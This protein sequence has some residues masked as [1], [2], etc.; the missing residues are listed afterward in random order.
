M[1]TKIVTIDLDARSYDIYIGNSLLF[2][3]PDF[4]PQDVAGKSI[5]I[6]TDTNV[7]SYA[8]RI[9]TLLT[10]NNARICAVHTLPAGEGTKSFQRVEEVCGWMLENGLSRDSIVMAVGG[11][12][13]GDLTG[14]CASVVMRGVPY[15]QVPTTLL[16]Q[17]DRSVGGKTGINSKQ[18]KNLRSEERRVGKEGKTQ[19]KPAHQQRA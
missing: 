11:G 7:Q 2:R 8:E 1:E 13:I 3:M 9:H 16:S 10:E 18:G 6:V 19:C 14:F 12:V 17:V 4:M 5:F 15:I